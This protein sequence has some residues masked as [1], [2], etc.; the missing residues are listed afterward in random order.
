MELSAILY[1][2]ALNHPAKAALITPTDELSYAELY[3][4][5]WN[6]AGKLSVERRSSGDSAIAPRVGLLATNPLEFIT[7]YYAGVL[8][9]ISVVVLDPAW[10]DLRLR[11]VIAD[12]DLEQIICQADAEPLIAELAPGITCHRIQRHAEAQQIVAPKLIDSD[13]ELMVVFTS[14]TTTTPKAICRSRASWQASLRVGHRTLHAKASQTTL[15]PGPLA[16]G[17]SLYAAVE[18]LAT[19]GT[20]MLSGRWN[21]HSVATLLSKAQCTRMVA[22]PSILRRV[23]TEN[24]HQLNHLQYVVC[25]GEV[26]PDPLRESY[27]VLE[28]VR[29]VVE[30][31]G[32]SEHSL[33]AYRNSSDTLL[34]KSAGFTGRP[35]PAVDIQVLNADPQTGIGEIFVHSPMLA[36][37]YHA[38]SQSTF[39]RNGRRVSVQDHGKYTRGVL[40]MAGRAGGMINLGGNNLYPSEVG[41]ALSRALGIA[42]VRLLLTSNPGGEAKLVAFMLASELGDYRDPQRLFERLGH[43][44]PKYKIPHEMALLTRWPMT[45]SGKI[46]TSRLIEARADDET[47]RVTLR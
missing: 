42:E 19:G 15:I 38:T 11:T 40:Q 10:P 28:S 16:H 35:F 12:I 2:R 7:G 8:S 32:T 6:L 47:T 13:Q 22:V 34:P 37:D 30:Y 17:L 18:T 25:G 26:L 41:D 31:Y 29:D 21:S 3:S 33:I 20:A 23:L 5:A 27:E 36:N 44:L 4:S 46:S 45:N 9:G 43:H 14:G 1:Q 24:Q 39:R